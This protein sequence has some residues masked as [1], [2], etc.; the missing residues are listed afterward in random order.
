VLLVG[1]FCLD[2]DYLVVVHRCHHIV[3]GRRTLRR[4]KQFFNPG[5]R[6]GLRQRVS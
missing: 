5:G 3:A 4:R 6:P 2:I 1:H